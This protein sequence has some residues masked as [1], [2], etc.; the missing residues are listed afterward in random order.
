MEV[1]N[2]KIVIRCERRNAHASHVFTM[3]QI[4]RLNVIL[5]L[6]R[7]GQLNQSAFSI[8]DCEAIDQLATLIYLMSPQ[9]WEHQL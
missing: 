8:K 9:P 6:L 3:A 1:N 5:Q 7:Q 4:Q 2:Y